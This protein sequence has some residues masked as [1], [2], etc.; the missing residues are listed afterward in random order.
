YTVGIDGDVATSAMIAD[1]GDVFFGGSVRFHGI[2]PDSTLLWVRPLDTAI[3]MASPVLGPG[4][5]L[6]VGTSGGSL[7]SITPASGGIKWRLT[8]ARNIRY[9][10]P[11]VGPD[12]TIYIGTR[13]GLVAVTDNGAS[14][15]I[16]WR[17]DA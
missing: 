15:A 3:T 5:T 6:Y 13:D 14:A 2:K 11:A 8:V 16:K 12:G 4:G 9:A 17:L 7:Y 1:N 10:A